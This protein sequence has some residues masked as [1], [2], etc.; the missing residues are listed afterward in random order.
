VVV[1][2][3]VVVRRAY[4]LLFFLGA[5]LAGHGCISW[6]PSCYDSSTFNSALP[7][8]TLT[9]DSAGDE[10]ALTSQSGWFNDQSGIVFIAFY[11]RRA[12]DGA[13]PRWREVDLELPDP[14]TL[15]ATTEVKLRVKGNVRSNPTA[16]FTV[17]ET[18]GTSAPFPKATTDDYLRRFAILITSDEAPD[19][20]LALTFSA[21]A[22]R[23]PRRDCAL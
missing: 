10:C 15:D 4:R 13:E 6:G 5:A 11:C 18:H 20:H 3:I 23:R 22:L 1:A 17:V 12:V 9:S 8:A 7:E 16:K 19:L 21:E 14:R 2:T